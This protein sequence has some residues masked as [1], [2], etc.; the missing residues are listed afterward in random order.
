[1]VDDN[2]EGAR[3]LARLLRSFGHEAALAHDGPSALDAAI[4]NPPDVILLDI[5]LPGMDG[6]EVARRL[7]QLDGPGRALLVALTGY[8]R[9]DD[10]RRSREAGFDHH[11]IKPVDPQALA[12]LLARHHRLVP[13]PLN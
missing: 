3:L 5:G 7:R 9:E 4:A 10:M 1:V 6:F 12:D 8:G 2:E 13:Q 11:L